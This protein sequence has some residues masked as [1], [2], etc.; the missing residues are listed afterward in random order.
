VGRLDTCPT[1]TRPPP[2]NGWPTG[3]TMDLEGFTYGHLG[4]TSGAEGVDMRG[5]DVCWW[6]WW[7]ERD[8][9]FSSQPYVQLASVMTAHGDQDN[10]AHI[11][12]Y[13][14][15]RET[16]MAWDAGNYFRWMLLALLNILAGYG[17]GSYTFRVLWWIVGL[18]A[19][20]VV[21]LKRSPGAVQKTL[22]WRAGASLNRVL[23]G[24]EINREF[25]T[26]FDDPERQRLRD[27][28]VVLFSAFVVVGWVLGLFLVA[29]MSGL[30]QHS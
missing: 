9:E 11:L 3:R 23:P 24:I 8:N 16:Q 19:I 22:L 10:A 18:T 1:D 5:R 4:S 6:R 30:T 12:Y 7:L 28:Q 27:W 17:I 21:L 20:G 15:V 2:A 25:V 29:A 14:R 26:F 13:G